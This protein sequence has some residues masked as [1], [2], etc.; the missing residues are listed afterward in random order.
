MSR[1]AVAVVLVLIALWL[2]GCGSDPDPDRSPEAEAAC[3]AEVAKRLRAEQRDL[4]YETT[5]KRFGSGGWDV[6]G[7]VATVSSSPMPFICGVYADGDR[8]KGSLRVDGVKVPYT[9]Q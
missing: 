6:Q 5:V 8:A 2:P 1:P 7:T 4:R 9:G 3:E